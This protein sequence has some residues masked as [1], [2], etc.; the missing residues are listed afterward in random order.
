MY[1]SSHPEKVKILISNVYVIVRP[2]VL[3][4][5]WEYTSL[6]VSIILLES[7]LFTFSILNIKRVIV[8]EN[9]Q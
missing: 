1:A 9:L 6:I 4:P 5:P 7:N 8:L 2:S 3:S